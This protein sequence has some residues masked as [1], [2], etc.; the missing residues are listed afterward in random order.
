MNKVINGVLYDTEKAVKLASWCCDNWD[1][2]Y[3]ETLYQKP[4]GDLFIHVEGGMIPVQ[5]LIPGYTRYVDETIITNECFEVMDWAEQ[6]LT[7]KEFIEIFG[8]VEE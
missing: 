4:N 2:N 5:G 1:G 6:H 3:S 7:G 8:A